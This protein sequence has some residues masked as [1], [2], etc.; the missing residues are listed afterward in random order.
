[1]NLGF[2][3]NYVINLKRHENRKNR[4]LS[5]LGEENTI[6]IDAI[7]GKEFENDNDWINKHLAP[8]VKWFNS[9]SSFRTSN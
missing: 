6:V 8:D 5:I 3:K 4:T 1:M 2:G 7:D 9:A